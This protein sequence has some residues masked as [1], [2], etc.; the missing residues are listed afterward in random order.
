MRPRGHFRLC[1]RQYG[2]GAMSP[3]WGLEFEVVFCTFF[4]IPCSF[5]YLVPSTALLRPGEP[6]VKL[7]C[8]EEKLKLGGGGGGGEFMCGSLND[9]VSSSVLQLVP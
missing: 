6:S 3:F 1:G 8:S 4:L 9:A 5:T 2:T 7:R